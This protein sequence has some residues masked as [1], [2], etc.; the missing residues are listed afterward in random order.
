MIALFTSSLN[1]KLNFDYRIMRF[2]KIIVYYIKFYYY[3]SKNQLFVF[4][5]FKTI[6]SRYTIINIYRNNIQTI[7]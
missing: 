7:Y 3:R 2:L 6:K 5:H 4:Y 1:K